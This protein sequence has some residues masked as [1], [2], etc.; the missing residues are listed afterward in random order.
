MSDTRTIKSFWW[1]PGQPT[2]R[3]FGILTL[4]AKETPSLELFGERGE[5]SQNVQ[6]VGNVIHGMDE[7]GKPITLLCV[8]TDLRVPSDRF[9]RLRRQLASQIIEYA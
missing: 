6:P 4:E 3:W 7:H 8:L 1:S 5:S 2:T 9:V